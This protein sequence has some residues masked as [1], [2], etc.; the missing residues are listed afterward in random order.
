MDLQFL[1]LPEVDGFWNVQRWY[2]ALC[3]FKRGI[4]VALSLANVFALL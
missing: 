1:V 2:Y 4:V 3:P